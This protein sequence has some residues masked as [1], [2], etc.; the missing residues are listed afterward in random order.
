MLDRAVVYILLIIEHNV[1]VSPE[2]LLGHHYQA[3]IYP[4]NARI[5]V[6]IMSDV[7][8]PVPHMSLW[9]LHGDLCLYSC[10]Q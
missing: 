6:I 7:T 3:Y 10:F 8:P 5:M 4:I 1:D 2:K 9:C